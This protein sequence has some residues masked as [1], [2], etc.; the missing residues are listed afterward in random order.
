M[1]IIIKIITFLSAIFSLLT[2]TAVTRY[3]YM[4]GSGRYGGE[5]EEVFYAFLGLFFVFCFCIADNK[6][7][8]IPKKIAVCVAVSITYTLTVF[9]INNFWRYIC[10]NLSFNWEAPIPYVTFLGWD[11]MYTDSY[12]E[13]RYPI[14]LII[15]LIL[16]GLK[17][18]FSHTKTKEVLSK[19]S[20]VFLDWL[21]IQILKRQKITDIYDEYAE[22]YY[23]GELIDYV[24]N[25]PLDEKHKHQLM[26]FT[27]THKDTLL[28]ILLL[29]RFEDIL[30]LEEYT[31]Y[32]KL[33]TDIS[34]EYI[35]NQ[36]AYF[37]GAKVKYHDV[38]VKLDSKFNLNKQEES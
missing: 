14:L 19:W 10:I 20:N 35:A 3:Y 17:I 38:F 29:A 1:K 8:T 4:G 15:M 31:K 28:I 12:G 25:M 33:Y 13:Y 36:R 16:C 30:T 9:L 18:F 6:L 26:E 11:A 2:F 27:D 37:A 21:Y 22:D 5:Y 7:K 23:D 32:R 24:S 34:E